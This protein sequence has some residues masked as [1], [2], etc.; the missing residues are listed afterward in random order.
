M[1]TSNDHVSTTDADVTAA[2]AGEDG[3]VSLCK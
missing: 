2:A 3:I 1:M